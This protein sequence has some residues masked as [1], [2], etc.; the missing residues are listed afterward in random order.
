MT[1]STPQSTPQ[2]SS[3]RTRKWAAGALVAAVVALILYAVGALSGFTQDAKV[4]AVR[5]GKGAASRPES[6]TES[7]FPLSHVCRWGDGTSVD[8]VP[9]WL[10]PLLYAAL[11]GVVVC[12]ALAVRAALQRKKELVHE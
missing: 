9:G 7:A 12:S 4:C 11:T 10:N 8:L 1:Q 3:T 5:A 2:S 6:I